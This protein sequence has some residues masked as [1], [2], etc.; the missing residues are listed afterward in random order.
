M[1]IREELQDKMNKTITRR[2]FVGLSVA[3]GAT[4]LAGGKLLGSTVRADWH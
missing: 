3:T 4:I 1:V 2:R